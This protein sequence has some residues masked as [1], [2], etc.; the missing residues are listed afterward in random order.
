MTRKRARK[1]IMSLRCFERN[2][3]NKMLRDADNANEMF[4]LMFDGPN[5]RITHEKSV[6]RARRNQHVYDCNERYCEQDLVFTTNLF[7]SFAK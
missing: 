7:R 2:D 6:K 1:L 3:A 4:L 5:A